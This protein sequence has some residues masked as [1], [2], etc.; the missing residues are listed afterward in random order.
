MSPKNLSPVEKD[1]GHIDGILAKHGIIEPDVHVTKSVKTGDGA[2]PLS[3]N[4][5]F[6]AGV[7]LTTMVE[8]DD[9][10]DSDGE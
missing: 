5:Q 3:N 9:A 4:G 10:E 8:E 7:G 2:P 1:G 6:S